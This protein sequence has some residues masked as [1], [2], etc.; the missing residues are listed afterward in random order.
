MSVRWSM[1]ESESCVL[2][3]IRA[4]SLYYK[5]ERGKLLSKI[6]E[7][8][9]FLTSPDSVHSSL[10]SVYMGPLLASV[11]RLPDPLGKLITDI[12]YGLL[13]MEE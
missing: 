4:L 5:D 10:F 8:L 6:Y 2:D 1:A 11:D 3:L 13:F 12:Y 7:S 9:V